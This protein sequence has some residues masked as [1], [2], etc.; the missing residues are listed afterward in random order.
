MKKIEFV[1]QEVSRMLETI[2]SWCAS[3]GLNLVFAAI[4]LIVGWFLT[5]KLTTLVKK[6]KGYAKLD[7]TVAIFLSNACNIALKSLLIIVVISMIG[8]PMAS[9]I[10]VL[11]AAGATIGLALQGGLSNIAG[12]ILI[13]IFRPFR[14]GDYIT[15]DGESGTVSD[16]NLFYTVMIPN[17][18]VSNAKIVNFSH[19]EIRRVDFEFTVDYTANIDGVMALLEKI[20]KE[21]EKVLPDPAVSSLIGAYT[22]KGIT[23]YLRA[24]CQSSDYWD[25]FFDINKTVH[26]EFERFGVDFAIPKLDVHMN[27][28]S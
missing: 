21:N 9:V 16:I 18:T 3:T 28:P 11:A 15:S 19:E 8:I 2:L 5:G 27:Q 22:D 20:G 24:W 6:S 13:T 7:Q 4:I 14:V 1:F 25:V 26:D 23:V 17:G 10:T 12:G